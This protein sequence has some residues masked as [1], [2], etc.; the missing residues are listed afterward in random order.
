MARAQVL[1]GAIGC[2]MLLGIGTAALGAATPAEAAWVAG[3]RGAAH[4]SAAVVAATTEIKCA[5]G[6]TLLTGDYADISWEAVPGA[7]KYEVWLRNASGSTSQVIAEPTGTTQRISKGLLGGLV[8][9]LLT[10]LLGGGTAYVEIVTVHGSGWKSQPGPSAG[11]KDSSLLGTG[12][13]G[14]IT[15]A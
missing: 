11:I 15:C 1:G 14:G 12:V 7:S 8:S 2:S 9:G 5:K 13:L 4:V 6:W 10:L 3:Q